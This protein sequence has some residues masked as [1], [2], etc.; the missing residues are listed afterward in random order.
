MTRPPALKFDKQLDCGC[1]LSVWVYQDRDKVTDARLT[2]NDFAKV[3]VDRRC[4]RASHSEEMSV[5][6]Q[7][8]IAI[9]EDNHANRK[10][11]Q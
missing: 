2:W 4:T 11:S 6:T 1:Q 3:L 10:Q 8:L 7:L 9:V 5:H